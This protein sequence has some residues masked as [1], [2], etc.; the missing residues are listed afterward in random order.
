MNKIESFFKD[1]IDWKFYNFL[2]DRLTKYED[3]TGIKVLVSVCVDK[4]ADFGDG[5]IIYDPYKLEIGDGVSAYMDVDNINWYVIAYNKN[6]LFY[7][8]NIYHDEHMT[9]EVKVAQTDII[10]DYIKDKSVQ[11]PC[12][13]A[14]LVV[15]PK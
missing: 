1:K 13:F 9:H 6:G 7:L 10:Y 14:I 4:S 2:V 5:H 15:K 11:I 8:V 12:G 3:E